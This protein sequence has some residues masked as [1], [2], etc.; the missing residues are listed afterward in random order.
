MFC[1]TGPP[2]PVISLTEASAPPSPN[3]VEVTGPVTGPD[4]AMETLPLLQSGG[5]LLDPTDPA[6]KENHDQSNSHTKSSTC[7]LADSP[8]DGVPTVSTS[9]CSLDNHDLGSHSQ[10]K[11]ISMNTHD[12]EPTVSSREQDNTPTCQKIS[13]NHAKDVNQGTQHDNHVATEA[14]ATYQGDQGQKGQSPDALPSKS[15]PVQSSGINITNLNIGGR[16]SVY[17]K[18][19]DAELTIGDQPTTDKVTLKE[20]IPVPEGVHSPLMAESSQPIQL[21]TADNQGS[22]EVNKP[23]REVLNLGPDAIREAHDTYPHQ[24]TNTQ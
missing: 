4:V 7:S 5:A 14:T 10:S 19:G 9:E 12:E 2:S 13:S 24:D 1:F 6:R 3:C 16:Q 21:D 22:P 8:A 23:E 20:K 11:V 18:H 15:K 17:M